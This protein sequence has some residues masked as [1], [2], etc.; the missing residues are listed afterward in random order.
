MPHS[1][2]ASYWAC[3][4]CQVVCSSL[5]SRRSVS[6]PRVSAP[7][8][9]LAAERVKKTPRYP[10]GLRAGAPTAPITSGAQP[11]IPTAPRGAEDA[12]TRR[13]TTAG[14]ISAISWA[15]KLPIEKPRRSTG[16]SSSASRNAMASRAICVI[17]LGVEPVDQGG[18]PV[19]EIPAEVLE[20]QEGRR[21]FADLAIHVVD[22]VRSADHFGGSRQVGAGGT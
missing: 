1:H 19:V 16:P 20:E 13:R 18:I 5:S 12:R 2:T 9:R 3:R 22:P 17:V 8:C 21:L 6:R 11:C 14:L 4:V 7:A 10:S 15:T